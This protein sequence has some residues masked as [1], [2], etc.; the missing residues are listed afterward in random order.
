MTAQST[1]IMSQ[2]AYLA[3]ERASPTKHEF[4]R[5]RIFAM[6]GAKAAHNLITGNTLASLHTQLRR[7]PCQVYP[8]DM[9]LRVL[10]TGL[11]TYPD[12]TVVCGR[13]RFTDSIQDTLS[14]QLFLSK[15]SLIPPSDMIVV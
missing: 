14:I 10:T 6:A 8:S 15:C 5:G 2:E 11:H 3:F 9:R 4:F 13:P 12:I 1:P 7:T